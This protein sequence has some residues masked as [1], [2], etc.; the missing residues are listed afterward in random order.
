M[1]RGND[2]EK[3]LL[4]TCNRT[5]FDLSGS[6][7]EEIVLYHKNREVLIHKVWVKYIEGSSSDAGVKLSIGDSSDDDAYFAATSEI[8]KA[9]GYS[10]EYDTGS[11]TLAKVPKDTPIIIKNA[12]GKTGAGTCVVGF[13]YTLN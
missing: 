8:S 11:I 9:A 3:E 1:I 6:A 13:S 4:T 7:A 12:G 10:A 5:L 2:L